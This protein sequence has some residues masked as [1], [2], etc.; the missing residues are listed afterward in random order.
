MSKRSL[1]AFVCGAIQLRDSNHKT[2]PL[3]QMRR[4]LAKIHLSFEG[5]ILSHSG[6]RWSCEAD[7]KTRSK[8][9]A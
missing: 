5:V 4:I 1:T 7:I 2:K 3:R 8:N 6:S 9:E